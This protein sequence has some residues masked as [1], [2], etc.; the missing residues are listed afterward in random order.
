[1]SIAPACFALKFHLLIDFTFEFEFR[2]CVFQFHISSR[3]FP[4][5]SQ[6]CNGS[7]SGKPTSPVFNI[8]SSRDFVQ[9]S[10]TEDLNATGKLDKIDSLLAEMSIA[11]NDWEI[12]MDSA[13]S[14]GKL[15]LLGGKMD[16][17]NALMERKMVMIDMRRQ[18]HACQ[19]QKEE[20]LEQLEKLRQEIIEI[21]ENARQKVTGYI[22]PRNNQGVLAGTSNTSITK[23][24]QLVMI[25]IDPLSN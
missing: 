18:I 16:D 14:V 24:V 23:L 7:M 4:T 21:L 25:H 11:I 10:S 8:P 2:F 20:G 15:A 5:G 1:M 13:I 9:Q 3:D 17:F 12:Q 6:I 19:E 22:I